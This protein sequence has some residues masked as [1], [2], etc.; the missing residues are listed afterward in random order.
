M[1]SQGTEEGHQSM[2]AMFAEEFIDATQHRELKHL[3]QFNLILPVQTFKIVIFVFINLN[4]LSNAK[5]LS[6]KLN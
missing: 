3:R 1:G 2:S 4:F 5:W 6:L